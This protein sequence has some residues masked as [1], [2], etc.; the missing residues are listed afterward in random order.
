LRTLDIDD[1]EAASVRGFS[2]L[3]TRGI[4]S[5]IYSRIDDQGD[6]QHGDT[7]YVSRLGDYE[8]WAILDGTEVLWA[9]EQSIDPANSDMLAVA[10]TYNIRIR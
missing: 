1:I 8:C 2:R 9:D 7:R 6:L 4:A 3:L 10:A 5:W